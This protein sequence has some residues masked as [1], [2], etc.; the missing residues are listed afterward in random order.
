MILRPQVKPGYF[1]TFWVRNNT[2]FPPVLH[3]RDGN[4][5]LRNVPL[6]TGLRRGLNIPDRKAR[7]VAQSVILMFPTVIPIYSLFYR[8]CEQVYLRYSWVIPEY[9][10]QKG[11]SQRL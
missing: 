1:L 6:P 9:S 8:G 7:T 5:P 11:G 10:C 3:F 4:K 2:S